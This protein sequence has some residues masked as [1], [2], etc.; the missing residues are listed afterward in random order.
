MLPRPQVADASELQQQLVQ[1][2][3]QLRQLKAC[4]EVVGSVARGSDLHLLLAVKHAARARQLHG[5]DSQECRAAD[6]AMGQAHLAR[7]GAACPADDA[8]ASP[9]VGP[10]SKAQDANDACCPLSLPGRR[11]GPVPPELLGRMAQARRRLAVGSSVATQMGVMA[12]RQEQPEQG[13]D[14]GGQQH[15]PVQE[16]AGA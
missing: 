12:W 8:I 1:P 11:Y 4:L 13:K 2:A 10:H 15:A 9:A 7:W 14:A 3:E 6:L 5:G 16:A